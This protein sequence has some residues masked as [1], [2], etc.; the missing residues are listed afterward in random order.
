[1]TST[2][3][4]RI[5]SVG[6]YRNRKGEKVYLTPSDDYGWY[7]EKNNWYSPLGFMDNYEDYNII[8]KWEEAPQWNGKI[9]DQYKYTKR[10]MPNFFPDAPIELVTKDDVIAAYYAQL[11]RQADLMQDDAQRISEL[12][13]ALGLIQGEAFFLIKAIEAT[14]P[15]HE[16]LLRANDIEKVA[17]KALG[18]CDANNTVK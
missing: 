6:F 13:G 7:D 4:F 8:A 1:M 18:D 14:D 9:D 10:E 2:N 15:V 5:D 17:K 16:L 12:S 11:M 3:N